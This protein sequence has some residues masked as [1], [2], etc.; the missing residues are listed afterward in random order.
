[1]SIT[2]QLFI[3]WLNPPAGKIIKGILFSDWPPEI[4][5]VRPI[6]CSVFPLLV[7]QEK[8]SFLLIY[9]IS[10]LWFY[11]SWNLLIWWGVLIAGYQNR[12][13]IWP[14]TTV[15]S[16]LQNSTTSLKRYTYMYC[17]CHT[18]H[19]LL[20]KLVWVKMAV[21]EYFFFFFLYFNFY[22]PPLCLAA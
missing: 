5:T 17:F 13:D 8:V 6:A 14:T 22:W 20:T 9:L 21:S 1:M 2:A 18:L 11:W 15:S 16:P 12:Q 19:P 3:I 7:L 10:F 4:N